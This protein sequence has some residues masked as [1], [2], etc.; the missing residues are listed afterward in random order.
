MWPA[1]FSAILAILPGD[2]LQRFSFGWLSIR[3]LKT[4]VAQQH[5]TDCHFL[6]RRFSIFSRM[7]N[8]RLQVLRTVSNE[9]WP[10]CAM[11]RWL[12]NSWISRDIKYAEMF[13]H[14]D[15]ESCF[16]RGNIPFIY[17]EEKS[18]GGVQKSRTSGRCW[19]WECVKLF[20]VQI[21]TL[22]YP[23]QRMAIYLSL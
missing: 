5:K 12:G 7:W 16:V 9:N 1:Y 2:H 20:I 6:L 18:Y 15:T 22:I 8:R 19:L 17:F 4:L 23:S 11:F 14:L 3:K 10:M 13:E 21:L